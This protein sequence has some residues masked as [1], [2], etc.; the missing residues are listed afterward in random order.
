M[1]PIRLIFVPLWVLTL[2][3]VALQGATATW[4]AKLCGE[5]QP[6]FIIGGNPNPLP[7][8]RIGERQ[9]ALV[10]QATFPLNLPGLNA[11]QIGR[12]QLKLYNLHGDEQFEFTLPT[13]GD[14]AN[15]ARVA[16]GPNHFMLWS[17]T[18]HHNADTNERRRA[19]RRWL[20]DMKG[21]VRD[22][23]GPADFEPL[24]INL[25]G[26]L[27]ASLATRVQIMGSQPEESDRPPQELKVESISSMS[28]LASFDVRRVLGAYFDDADNLYVLR[29]HGDSEAPYR[30]LMYHIALD[31][32]AAT[33]YQ[34]LWST[35]VTQTPTPQGS[36][37]A[38][39][40]VLLTPGD[41]IR[42][43]YA[44]E[45][46]DLN[47][48]VVELDANTGEVLSRVQEAY[49]MQRVGR[50]MGQEVA[51]LEW[52]IRARKVACMQNETAKVIRLRR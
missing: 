41:R 48:Q 9:I 15:I 26:D 19:Y 2:L 33:H 10:S 34:L 30:T 39:P 4:G 40:H 35:A 20:V 16:V 42:L 8:A 29:W 47:T 43:S 7:Q 45:T 13:D 28:T 50:H 5:R 36:G 1:N 25:R 14:A 6:R 23:S 17:T 49:S 27:L 44:H 52:N 51:G 32:Y 24:A 38:G 3:G 22:L 11:F 18:E 37:P 12:H 46:P 31:K 21:G